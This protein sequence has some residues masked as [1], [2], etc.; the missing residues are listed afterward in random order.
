MPADVF[1]RYPPALRVE[2]PVCHAR[3]AQPCTSRRRR[4]TDPHNE[5]R[6]LAERGPTPSRRERRL[7]PFT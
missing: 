5:R 1:H 3:P 2:C 4:R 7:H 6:L